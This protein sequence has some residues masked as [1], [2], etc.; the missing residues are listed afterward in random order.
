MSRGERPCYDHQKETYRAE[1]RPADC[2]Q[3]CTV[4]PFFSPDHSID[5][6]MQLIDGAEE[7]IDLLEP[8]NLQHTQYIFLHPPCMTMPALQQR[9]NGL[10]F[11]SQF[12]HCVDCALMYT[13]LV[14][15]I[16]LTPLV[17]STF[18]WFSMSSHTTSP[19]PSGFSSWSNCTYYSSDCGGQCVGCSLQDQYNEQFP[20]FGALMNAVHLRNVKVRFLTNDFSTETCEGKATPLDWMSLNGVQ[21]RM[22]TTTTFMH[23]KAMI[24]DKGKRTMVSSVNFSKTSFTMNREAG[25]II[26]DCKCQLQDFYQ[27]VFDSDWDKAYDYQLQRK[28]SNSEIDFITNST[29][30]PF[31]DL[32]IV[33]VKGAFRTSMNTYTGVTIDS[34]YTAPDYARTTFMDMLNTVKTSLKIHI[35][36]ITDQ[37]ICEKILD[38]YKNGVNVSVLVGSYIVSY[39]DYKQAQVR[40]G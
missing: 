30:M 37:D 9:I 19:P 36:Q 12:L 17:Y 14:P 8:S 25:V 33:P 10:H 35:Y 4:T 5:A 26:E 11:S 22:Y 20:I 39:D 13:S 7:S 34:F 21:I 31:P 18:S 27:K 16:T 28:Y 2:T 38:L 6:Y 29:E 32:H 40:G 3:A 24:V 15:E 1:Y 23:A